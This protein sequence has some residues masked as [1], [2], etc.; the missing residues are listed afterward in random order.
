[1]IWIHVTFVQ[2]S[3]TTLAC[4]SADLRDSGLHFV[5]VAA[6]APALDLAE[7]TYSERSQVEGVLVERGFA[8]SEAEAAAHQVRED[9]R[10][11]ALPQ[12]D[13]H[14]RRHH[15]EGRECLD[16]I[17]RVHVEESQSRGSSPDDSLSMS[18]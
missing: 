11:E 10:T 6:A 17:H 2:Y 3:D 9:G 15:R 4:L 1:M 16:G 7:D 13:G 5:Q 12:E 8:R 14:R 18:R